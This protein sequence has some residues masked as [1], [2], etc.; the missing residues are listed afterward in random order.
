LRFSVDQAEPNSPKRRD[1]SKYSDPNTRT[2]VQN[3]PASLP[4]RRCCYHAQ[5]LP[6]SPTA[7]R[8]VPPRALPTNSAVRLP[9]RQPR[10]FA[11]PDTLHPPEC[12]YDPKLLSPAVSHTG[13]RRSRRQR[14]R[15]LILRA[16]LPPASFAVEGI[17][18]PHDH[19]AEAEILPGTSVD[20]RSTCRPHSLRKSRQFPFLPSIPVS[21]AKTPCTDGLSGAAPTLRPGAA[22]AGVAA[23]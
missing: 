22:I 7:R 11:A 9:L 5:R 17:S 12:L 15:R 13:T 2:P 14:D 8:R 20:R 23:V 4:R 18:Q 10:V 16:C 3:L 1:Q 19:S 6:V 21:C